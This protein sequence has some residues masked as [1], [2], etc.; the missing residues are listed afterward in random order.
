MPEL[1]SIKH[2]G[3]EPCAVGS[4]VEVLVS[5]F[6]LFFAGFHLKHLLFFEIFLCDCYI[7]KIEQLNTW[8]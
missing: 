4:I 3:L 1:T 5:F 7:L 6:L 8:S 2:S